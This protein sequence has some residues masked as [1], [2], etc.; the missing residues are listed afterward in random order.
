MSKLPQNSQGH[1][2]LSDFGISKELDGSAAMLKTAV[3]SYHY[4]SPERLLS[5]KYDASGD[6]WSVGITI[7]Q[8]WNKAYPFENV[9]DTPIDLLSQLETQDLSYLLRNCSAKMKDILRSMLEFK[10]HKRATCQEIADSP[11]FEACGVNTLV[12]AQNVRIH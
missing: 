3:G 11:W 10:P 4:M 1:V 7:L 9:S 6:I 12:D 2:K 8:L 5:E